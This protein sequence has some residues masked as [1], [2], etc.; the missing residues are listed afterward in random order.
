MDGDGGYDTDDDS[1]DE[2]K[3]GTWAVSDSDDE[4]PERA[5]HLPL[6]GGS[7][8]CYHAASVQG[9]EIRGSSPMPMSSNR[10]HGFMK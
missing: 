9:A 7:A 1:E 10:T 3:R 2:L 6:D 4:E 8:W 5:R